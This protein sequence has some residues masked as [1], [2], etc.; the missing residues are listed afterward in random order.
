MMLKHMYNLGDETLAEAWVMSPYLQYF[1]GSA[2]FE[3]KFPCDP[4]DFVHFCKRIGEAGF[5][6]IFEY[7]VKMFGRKAEE[8]LVVS[9]ILNTTFPTDAR[10]Y[11]KVID[12]CNKIA[13]TENIPQRQMYTKTSKELLRATYNSDHPKRHKKVVAAM[14]KLHTI[15]G[16]QVRELER[17]MTEEQRKVYEEELTISNKVLTQTRHSKDK[18]YSRD[19]GVS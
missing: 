18:V 6:K 3:H 16:R 15:A 11:K 2:F 10:L 12:G 17:V 4:S 7:S 1:T 9:D 19:G 5:Q 14:R 13:H 8:S